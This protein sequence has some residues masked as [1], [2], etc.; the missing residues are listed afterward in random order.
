MIAFTTTMIVA[1]YVWISVHTARHEAQVK[2]SQKLTEIE[3]ARR[4]MITKLTSKPD[5]EA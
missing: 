1:G 4:A 5:R 3:A 2:R